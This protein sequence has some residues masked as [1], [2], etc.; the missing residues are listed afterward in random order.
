[1]SERTYYIISISFLIAACI[2]GIAKWVFD[3]PTHDLYM[4][5]LICM[6]WSETQRQQ[7]AIERLQRDLNEKVLA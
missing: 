4:W 6:L 5:C 1:M 2:S 7:K 3:A